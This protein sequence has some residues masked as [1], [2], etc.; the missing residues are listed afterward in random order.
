MCRT[1]DHKY[2][3]LS[4]AHLSVIECLLLCAD[5]SGFSSTP[6]TANQMAALSAGTWPIMPLK[7]VAPRGSILGL[8][9]PADIIRWVTVANSPKFVIHDRIFYQYLDFRGPCERFRLS[10]SSK[11]REAAVIEV[12]GPVM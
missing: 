5:S 8:C 4:T 10:D 2:K 3:L 6:L 7:S 9:Q 12:R 1:G 11:R